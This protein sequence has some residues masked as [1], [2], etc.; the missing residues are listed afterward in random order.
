[1]ETLLR[2][3]R[4]PEYVHVLLNP[5][6]VY[7]LLVG[8]LGLVVALILRSRRAQIVTLT[9][10][11]IS[12]ASAWPAYEFGQRGYDRVLSMADE[13]GHAWL[14]EHMHRAEKLIWIFYVLGAL[15]AIAIAAPLKWPKFSVPLAV[16]VI[17]AGAVTLGSGAYVAYAGGRVRHREFRNE[18]APPKRSEREQ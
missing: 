2:D 5:L 11:L 10:V 6:P 13:D 4:Q 17:L 8:W 12:S 14:D 1:M 9:L 15:S 3:L 18:P 16:V 7:G